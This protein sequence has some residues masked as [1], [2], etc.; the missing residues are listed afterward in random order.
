MAEQLVNG[1]LTACPPRTHAQC[2]SEDCGNPNDSNYTECKLNCDRFCLPGLSEVD[3]CQLNNQRINFRNSRGNE[4]GNDWWNNAIL[5]NLLNTG[6]LLVGVPGAGTITQTVGGLVD[7]QG[8]PSAP[9][10][11]GD[12]SAL[13]TNSSAT[14]GLGIIGLLAGGLIAAKLFKLF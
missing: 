8:M 12:C 11:T 7:P 13:K 14:G 9:Q 10:P 6:G 2:M 1:V 5:T 3:R 4:G